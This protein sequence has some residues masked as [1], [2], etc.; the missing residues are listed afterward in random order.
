[1]LDSDTHTR[2]LLVRER[3]VQLRRHARVIRP[4]APQGEP[5]REHPRLAAWRRLR[6]A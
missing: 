3:Q 5:R 1:M 2:Q 4:D 6:A